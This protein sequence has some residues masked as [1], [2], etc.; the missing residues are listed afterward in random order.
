MDI[1]SNIEKCVADLASNV[2][3]IAFGTKNVEQYKAAVKR[4]FQLERAL[5]DHVVAPWDRGLTEIQRFLEM[6]KQ[7]WHG[8]SRNRTN[9]LLDVDYFGA[10]YNYHLEYCAETQMAIRDLVN[11]LQTRIDEEEGII[12]KLT[13]QNLVIKNRQTE[14]EK[15][16]EKRGDLG[17]N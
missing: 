3:K 6:G 10:M 8:E 15:Y 14:L 9:E 12:A 16:L 7:E 2:E 13:A 5:G 11:A 17:S 4:L 1:A